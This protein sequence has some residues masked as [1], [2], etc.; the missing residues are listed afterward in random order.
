MHTTEYPLM[1]ITHK[2]T[3]LESH[4][5]F[6]MP[7]Q[8]PVLYIYPP[9][10]DPNSIENPP[11]TLASYTVSFTSSSHVQIKF[12]LKSGDYK[13]FETSSM[14]TLLFNLLS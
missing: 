14:F 10:R 3:L 5:F 1:N 9:K 12:Q 2:D 6:K 4:K 7:A 8:A 13:R 11:S